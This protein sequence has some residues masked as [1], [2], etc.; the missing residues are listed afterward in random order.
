MK[1][2]SN[3]VVYVL[4]IAAFFAASCGGHTGSSAASGLAA[5]ATPASTGNSLL[6]SLQITD[7]AEV[8]FCK[9]YDEALTEYVKRVQ[10]AMT[11]T[12]K[13]RSPEYADID[14]K[15]RDQAKE[16]EPQ[17]NSLR[18]TLATNPMELMKFEKF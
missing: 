15:F 4:I 6:D 13:L 12:A 18:T 5:G 9:L 7:P 3:P 17:V 16:L 10:I 8:K 1:K 2:V 11:D 14:K